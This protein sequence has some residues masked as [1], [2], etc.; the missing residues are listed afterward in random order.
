MSKMPERVF[1]ERL[2]IMIKTRRTSM[3]ILQGLAVLFLG[4]T[5]TGCSTA[6]WGGAGAGALGAG[7]GY[8]IQAERQMNA[9]NEDLKSGKI[10]QQEYDIRKDQ[11]QKGSLLK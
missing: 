3:R 4:I 8:E 10:T 2:I 9:L 7:A 1:N 6:F 5:L 11:I